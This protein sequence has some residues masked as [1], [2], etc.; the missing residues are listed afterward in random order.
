[1]NKCPLC[2]SADSH[3]SWFGSAEYGGREYAY[4]ECESCASLYCDPMPDKD[5]LAQMYGPEYHQRGDGTIDN[6]KEPERVISW[7]RSH[8]E[9]GLFIDYGCGEGELLNEAQQAGWRAIGTEYDAEVTQRVAQ[10]TGCE[11][12]TPAQAQDEGL[13]ADVL[14]LGD[15][16]EHLT[17]LETQMPEILRLLKP[18]GVLMAQGPLEANANAFTALL[19]ASKKIKTL[20]GRGNM[21]QMAPYHILLATAGGQRRFFQRFG[22][23]EILYRV[24]EV[25]W[26]APSHLRRANFKSPG[27]V[28]RFAARRGSRALSHFNRRWGNRYFYTGRH[29][30][31]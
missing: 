19:K 28:A 20:A 9:G 4:V 10:N 25:D 15:V 24:S 1:M 14:H 7:L 13:Q 26:P 22:L 6:P 8:P 27:T 17:R 29:K 11:V 3:P 12:M 5:A 23:K 16:V 2:G 31:L 21:A 30:K 18:G